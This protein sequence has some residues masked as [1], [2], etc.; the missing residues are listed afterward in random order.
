MSP[1]ELPRI[2]DLLPHREPMLLV[3]AIE[4][5]DDDGVVC[6]TRLRP[7]MLIAGEQGVAAVFGLEMGA[8]AAAVHAALRRRGASGPAAGPRHGYLVG[9]RAARFHDTVL[10]LQQELRI[11][12][13]HHG[14][15][16]PMA[17][18]DVAVTRLEDDRLLVEGRISVWTL[19]EE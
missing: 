14:S 10:P 9:I 5:S 7:D 3:D 2:E 8:Q 16:G 12:A 1:R 18:Y 19:P 11:E 13:R 17:L 15:A 4:T 6:S